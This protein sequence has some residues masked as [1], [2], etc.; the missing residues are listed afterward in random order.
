MRFVDFSFAKT[1]VER[2]PEPTPS[3]AYVLKEF[4]DAITFAGTEWQS[5]LEAHRQ[6]DST[7]AERFTL[8]QR[9]LAFLKGPIVPALTARFPMIVTTGAEADRV[10]ETS[11]NSLVICHLI[12]GEAVIAAGGGTRGEVRAALPD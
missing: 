3:E 1:W 12:V 5:F 2:T 4:G 8:K 6:V 7:R 9:M 11:G 10:T